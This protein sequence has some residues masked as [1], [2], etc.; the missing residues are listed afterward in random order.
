MSK[1]ILL[2]NPWIH[3][4]AAYDFWLKPLGLLYLGGLLRQN[5]HQ[6][7]FIDCLDPYHPEMLAR[8]LKPRRHPFGRG[9]FYRQII[10]KPEKLKFMPKNYCRY[11]IMPEIFR[12]DLKNNQDADIV[13]ITSMMTYWYPGVFEAIK[14]IK[15]ELPRVP[16][17]LGG[18]YA[19]LCLEHAV[20]Y[21]GADYV[22]SGAGE[23]QIIELLENL[24]GEK[25]THL[26]DEENLDSYPYPAFDLISKTQQ[27]P[28]TTSRGC[29]YRCSYCSSHILYKK[30]LR[31]N[32]VKVADEIEYWQKQSDIINFSFYD[33]ALLVE[34][35]KM[36]IPLLDEIKKRNLTC[37]FHCPNGLHLRE[38]DAEL[39]KLLYT[40]GFKTIRFGFETADFQRQKETGGKV[41]NKE[42]SE[43]VR[44]LK[45][46]GYTT[47]DIGIYLLCGLPGQRAT[48]VTESIDFVKKC[49]AK[50]MLAEYS[51]IP[52][53]KMW[54]DAVASSPFDIQAEPLYH[55]N[56]LL[57]C[58][59]D[60]F[61]YEV[62]TKIKT[63][64]KNN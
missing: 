32:P 61:T 8:G 39:A 59:N 53:T 27:L 37:Q 11:G 51:P 56:S 60:D 9:K 2:I 10:P 13:L 45:N 16:V 18:K 12:N 40:S 41:I 20:K 33:D 38:I 23:A 52:G 54:A 63:D 42:L 4:F 30:F 46:A 25:P 31:R 3:D 19:T 17:L 21:S 49:G 22:I 48:E 1:N 6:V 28:I 50:P 43:G 64:L 47:D 34:P 15:E 35:D 62:Y 44:H 55:N 14:I 36:I 24:F 57:P 26:P 29:P 7:N 58:R 5:G